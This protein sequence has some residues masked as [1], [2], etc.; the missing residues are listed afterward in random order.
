VPFVV[1]V[2]VTFAVL[3]V[4][5]S[6]CS[7]TLVPAAAVTVVMAHVAILL[8][9][10]RS[11][12]AASPAE[13]TLCYVAR[14]GNP[15]SFEEMAAL[16]RQ[17]EVG[18]RAAFETPFGR[19]L[20]CYADLTATGRY[21]HFVEAWMRRVRP[22]YANSHTAISSS[23]RVMTELREEARRLVRR[24]VRASEQDV[25]VFAG[26][27]ATAAIHKLV[28]LLGVRIPEPLERAYALSRA[29]PEAERPVV[30]VGPYEHHSNQLPWLES[31]ADVVEVGLDAHGGI[32]LADLEAKAAA[33]ARRPLRIG[34]FSAASNVTG[35]LS[36][37]RAIARALHRHGFYACFDYAAAAPYVPIDMHPEGDPE[38]RLD[39]IFVSSHKF[40]GGPEASGVLVAHRD[41]FRSRTPERPGGGTVDYVGGAELESVDYVARLDEREEGGT[42]AILGD[43]RAGVAFLV[44]EMVGP[45][46]ILAHELALA[47]RAVER[48]SKHP[49]VRVLGPHDVPRLAIVSFVIDRMHH[50]LVSA[51]LDQLFG[52]QNR[53]GCSCAG[54][55]GHRLLGIERAHSERFRALIR[56]GF[57]GIKPG[58]VRVSIPWYASE[59]DFEFLMR[60]VEFVASR[61]RDFVPAYELGLRDGVWRHRERPQPDVPPIELTVEALEEAAQS[62]AAGD[63]EQPLSEAQLRH[64]RARYLAE[65]TRAADLLA[66]RWRAE[67]PVWNP[68]TGE[69]ELEALAWFDWVHARA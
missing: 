50:D 19:R 21:L 22:F 59:E 39:A 15:R 64:E 65:A 56:R 66:A 31:I 24:N 41:L 44:K 42:P 6:A 20:I 51:L 8:A 61:G 58:W 57:N 62:F 33:Y 3:V 25:L 9:T 53:A 45:E 5:V 2:A 63:H 10:P 34:S 1:R 47:R 36:D 18:R 14:M 54:P 23:G 37:V 52:I 12:V 32:D 7:P 67:P 29:I 68:P 28:G 69:P 48:L 35:A 16:V 60:A 30:L 55:Y 27:G 40:V 11:S 38:G 4:T 43:I 46:R 13:A 17:H 26:A 49:N